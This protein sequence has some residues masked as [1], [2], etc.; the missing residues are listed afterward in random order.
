MND[1][2]YPADWHRHGE[3]P[4]CHPDG[5]MPHCHPD[6]KMPHDHPGLTS[7]RS[8]NSGGGNSLF[9]I[10]GII[11]VSLIFLGAA[12]SYYDPHLNFPVVSQVVCSLKG[13]TWYGGGLLESPG[14][15]AP[16]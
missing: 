3:M 5:K 2:R 9:K 6:G 12:M 8:S 10:I 4:H 13:D 1:Q 7:A 16:S 14:C 11:L 15:Y